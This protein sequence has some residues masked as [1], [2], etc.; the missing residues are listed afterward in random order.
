MFAIGRLLLPPAIRRPATARP[1]GRPRRRHPRANGL[2]RVRTV[3]L[4]VP[5]VGVAAVAGWLLAGGGLAPPEAL[6]G[7]LAA[8]TARPLAGTAPSTLRVR[9]RMRR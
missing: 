1:A 5:A 6:V 3:L 2:K 9:R 4:V 7:R 8:T